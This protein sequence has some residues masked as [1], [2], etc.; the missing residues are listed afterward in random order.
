M[1]PLFLFG[2]LRGFDQKK[3]LISEL[4]THCVYFEFM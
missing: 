4:D 1:A 2:V 3:R